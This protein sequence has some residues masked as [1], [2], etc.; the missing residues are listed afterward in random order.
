MDELDDFVMMIEEG[1]FSEAHVVLEHPWKVLRAESKDEGNILKGLINAASAFE[2]KR[3]GR[4]E[5]ALRIWAAYEKYRPLIET[6]D[7]PHK[8]MY[9]RCATVVEEKAKIYLK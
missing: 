7:S 4:D 8:R 5:A 3:I 6:V 1:R 9:Q 2:L